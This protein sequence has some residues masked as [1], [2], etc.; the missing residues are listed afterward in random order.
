MN[1]KELDDD[2][3]AKA[4]SIISAGQSQKSKETQV[5]TLT[6][7]Y[8]A[9]RASGY[10]STGDSREF[11]Q[12][13]Q[14]GLL[15]TAYEYSSRT[16]PNLR[17]MRTTMQ[18]S[19]K[20]LNAIDKITSAVK[21]VKGGLTSAQKDMTKKPVANILLPRSK[22][23][24]D[25]T[26]HKF[27]DVGESLLTRG[28]NTITG[29]LSNMASTAVFGAIESVTQGV[30]ADH[31]EQIYNTARSMYAGADNRTKIYTWEF[32]PRTPDDLNQI[33][34]IYEIFNFFSY[35]VTGNSQFAKDVKK[36]ID[37][38][39]KNTIINKVNEEVGAKTQKTFMESVTSFLSNVITV[40]NPTVWFIQ[41]FGTQSKYDGLAD[42]FGPAQI[43]S[44]RF[45]KAPDGNF[46]GLAIAPNMP[47]TFVL[48]VTFREI[49]T[50]N[51]ASIYGEDVL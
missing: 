20:L 18:K 11:D 19:Y 17:D 38:W 23:D 13:Y 29:V 48:E 27:N 49:L 7:Q 36:H 22:S 2:F 44:I 14:N 51:R 32:T 35:G 4:G 39:Y 16:T 30:M 21:S 8:P 1:F 25:V 45:D 6:A 15:F 26:S 37:D 9:E 31:G 12:L 24:S 42:I 50:Q 47:S 34:K 3:L 28:N 40:S 43:Q 46:N 41:N 10:D 5:K 33:L